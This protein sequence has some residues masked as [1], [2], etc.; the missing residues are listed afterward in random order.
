MDTHHVRCQPRSTASLRWSTGSCRACCGW[1]R[2]FAS[3]PLRARRRNRSGRCRRNSASATCTSVD[4]DGRRHP[5]GF[6]RRAYRYQQR[7]GFDA[8]GQARRHHAALA[9]PVAARA[10]PSPRTAVAASIPPRRRSRWFR[11]PPYVPL[12]GHAT[13]LRSDEARRNP[14]P[15]PAGSPAVAEPLTDTSRHRSAPGRR[16]PPLARMPTR[17]VIFLARYLQARARPMTPPTATATFY[18]DHVDYFNEGVRWT[19]HFI[20]GGRGPLRSPLARAPVHP[21][22]PR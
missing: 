21:P 22:R 2:F 6:R 7:K 15:P 10:C 9:H 1:P 17:C 18:G 3:L 16:F 14:I 4:V 12:A 5:A 19:S 11:L 20:A 13:V 8:T